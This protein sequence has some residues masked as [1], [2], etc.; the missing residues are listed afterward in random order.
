MAEAIQLL[1][2]VYEKETSILG[3]QL[4]ELAQMSASWKEGSSDDELGSETCVPQ[5]HR[6]EAKQAEKGRVQ[7]VG[8]EDCCMAC[9]WLDARSTASLWGSGLLVQE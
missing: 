6:W 1:K 5:C 2:Q 4:Q 8:Q 9:P 7:E 3:I